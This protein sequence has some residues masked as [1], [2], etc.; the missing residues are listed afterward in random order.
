MKPLY[1]KS[2]YKLA[3]PK[4]KLPLQCENCNETYYAYKVNI[5]NFINPN[6]HEKGDCCSD[7]CR[8]KYKTKKVKVKCFLC[9]TEIERHP[10]QLKI[11]PK[12]FCG[13][14]CALKYNSMH[15]TTGINRSKLEIWIQDQLTI[16]YPSIDIKYNNTS[17]INAE[18]DI[19]IPSLK[20]AFEINGIFHYKPIFGEEKLRKTQDKDLYKLKR[21]HECGIIFHVINTSLLR[22]FEVDKIKTIEI[23]KQHINTITCVIDK[24]IK[25]TRLT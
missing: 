12:S 16:L 6:R 13:K 9:G 18:L 19:Y 22:D 4:D 21:C 20:L 25:Q 1:T 11:Y 2:E 7:K 10:S 24:H 8:G 23:A 14:S 17:A 5:R 3:K 15:K